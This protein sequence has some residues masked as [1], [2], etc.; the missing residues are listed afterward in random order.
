MDVQIRQIGMHLLAILRPE[1][2]L[3]DCQPLGFLQRVLPSP[4]PLPEP[5]ACNFLALKPHIPHLLRQ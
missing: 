5:L 1:A 2:T 4:P 3:P